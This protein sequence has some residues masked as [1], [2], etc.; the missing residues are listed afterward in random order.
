MTKNIMQ[1][2]S[3][4]KVIRV[5]KDLLVNLKNLLSSFAPNEKTNVTVLCE[6]NSEYNFSSFSEFLEFNENELKIITTLTVDTLYIDENYGSVKIEF[7]NKLLTW[8]SGNVDITFNFHNED[9]Y[10]L[11]KNKLVQL[12]NNYRAPYSII[13]RTNL[14]MV[15]SVLVFSF[16]C[17]YTNCK[18][19]IFPT[20]VQ[21]LIGYGIM[22][23]M[24]ASCLLDGYRKLKHKIFPY[25]EFN[26][27]SNN[28][29]KYK[30]I[31]NIM[32]V[33]IILAFIVGLITNI[34][35][36]LFRF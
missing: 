33:S 6:D 27:W 35:S 5:N 32:G 8:V 10:Y 34:C 36:S 24:L 2:L 18:N 26:I 17:I 3:I 29:E 1:K 23:L 7:N 20:I 31:R 28:A 12:L 22:A 16:I 4:K 14:T 21:G 25:C 15:V 11:L 13:T 30:N 19:I 9:N